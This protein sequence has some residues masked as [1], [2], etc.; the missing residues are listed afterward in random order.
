[1]NNKL[2]VF[3]GLARKL[4]TIYNVRERQINT[5]LSSE[6]M[7][8]ARSTFFFWGGGDLI[9]EKLIIDS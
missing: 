5:Q 6:L 2:N 4:Q 8:K 9:I 3:R 7:Q 1:M